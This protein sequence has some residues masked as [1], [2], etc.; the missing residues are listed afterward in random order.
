MKVFNEYFSNIVPN[1]DIQRPPSII[2]HHD[3]KLNAIKKIENHPSILEIKKQIPSDVAF[4]FSFR[5]VNL[6]EIINEIKNLDESKPTLSNDIPTK[7]IKE[8]YD[9]F[10]TFITENFNNMIENSVFPDS[11]KQADIKLVYKKDSR[12]KKEKLQACKHF[13]QLI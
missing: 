13:T 5:K 11:L 7:V 8:N 2:L 12:N 6:A 4:P 10:A 9:I 1:L 3:P